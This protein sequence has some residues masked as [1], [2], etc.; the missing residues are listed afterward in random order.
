MCGICGFLTPHSDSNSETL[1]RMNARLVHRGPDDEGYFVEPGVG[2]A[3]RRLSIIDVAGG[4]QPLSNE[5]GTVWITYNGEIYN[6][7]ELRGEL[8]RLGHK[9]RTRSDTEMIV[10]ASEEWGERCVQRFRGMFAFGLWDRPRQRLTLARDRFGKKPLYYAFAG[11]RFLFGSE[12]KALLAEGSLVPAADLESLRLLFSLGFVPS[13]RTMFRGIRKLPAAHV[14][15]VEVKD[16]TVRPP[17]LQCYWDLPV[18]LSP[19]TSLPPSEGHLTLSRLEA[20]EHARALLREA[21]SIRRMSEVPLG[22]LLS[23][24]LDST[25]VVALLQSMA[26]EPV[27][28]VSISFENS[29]FDESAHARLAAEKLGTR[30]HIL[31]FGTGDFDLLPEATAHLEEPQCSATSLPIYLLYKAC[32][33]AGLTVVLTGEGADELFA[34][35]HWYRGDA[36]VQ[37]LLRLPSVARRSLSRFPLP[38]SGAARRVLVAVNG[39]RS[40]AERYQ[41]WQQVLSPSAL[42]RLFAT[43]GSE[44]R[45][46]DHDS[47][48]IHA[49]GN[50]RAEW[51][52]DTGVRDPRHLPRTQAPGSA[53]LA[54]MRYVESH[55]RMVDFINFEVDRLSMAHSV[56][57]RVPFLDHPLWE[58]I[59]QL[60]EAWLL[61][62]RQEKSLLR[63]IAAPWVPPETL[64]RTKWGLAAPHAEW[65]R[66]PGLVPWAEEALNPSSLE[67]T[68]YFHPGEVARLRAEHQARRA[69]HSRPL[70]GVLSTQI[71]H[72]QFG[73]NSVSQ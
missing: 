73:V 23:G 36:H 42:R 11:D 72:Q 35:Y 69:D 17:Q 66:Q 46:E 47:A 22:A 53:P 50:P 45:G 31:E 32:R 7:R 1:Q 71:W 37:K 25:T 20:V 41:L 3:A 39:E 67:E 58:F 65:L 10:H 60:P 64:G 28:T 34:G 70:F 57:A 63:E 8:L 26:V 52:W 44:A 14:M 15:V 29:R 18:T 21:V 40:V 24:G 49:F 68:G 38:M 48:P 55:S 33:E 2:L 62:G 59:C 4:H 16:G 51:G 56:E 61:R 43:P 6:H 19:V 12:I 13:P 9:F 30:H 5:D 54:E 27:H